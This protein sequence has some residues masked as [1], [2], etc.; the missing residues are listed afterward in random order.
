LRAERGTT[1][2]LEARRCVEGRAPARFHCFCVLP[3]ETEGTR[4]AEGRRRLSNSSLVS[5]SNDPARAS[6]Q[7]EEEH[8]AR[9][10]A[11]HAEEDEG[12]EAGGK[13]RDHKHKRDRRGMRAARGMLGCAWRGV[14]EGQTIYAIAQELGRGG[15]NPYAGVLRALPLRD[16]VSRSRVAG[17]V[18]GSR[19]GRPVRR[20]APGEGRSSQVSDADRASIFSGRKSATASR[21][22]ALLRTS[23]PRDAPRGR[24][25]RGSCRR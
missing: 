9:K 2:G 11:K 21:V 20:S 17:R 22:E 23:P 19:W 3:E 4:T 13:S 14:G 5:T 16:R 25:R 18:R 8:K 12:S 15:R 7:T 24:H 6:P 1:F 10:A